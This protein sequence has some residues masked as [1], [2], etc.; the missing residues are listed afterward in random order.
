MLDTVLPAAQQLRGPEALRILAGC[1][2]QK[3]H[4]NGNTVTSVTCRLSNGRRLEVQ[5]NTIV[6]AAGAVS[7]SLLLL[8]SGI[9][10]KQVGTHLAFNMGSPITAVFDRPIN[11]YDGL[12]IS[13][14]LQ[15]SPSQG[16]LLETWF[17][18]P[19][20]Q[21]LAMPGWFDDHYK[22]MQ[23][24]NHMSSVGVL[25][26]T[27][28]NATVRRA[29]LFGRE[30]AYTP[31]PGDLAKLV[32]GLILAGRIC[33]AGG[34]S[35]VLP[36]TWDYYEFTRADELE[37]LRHIIRQAGD[38]ALG[39][40]HPQGGNRLSQNAS[41]GVV[42][43]EFRVF[44]YDNLYVCDASVFPSSIGVNPQLTVMALAD[45]ASQFIAAAR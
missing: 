16:Y 1:E 42:N 10:G 23:R 2:A 44:G 37:R 40:G 29:G 38:V 43:P 39:T 17:N 13:H 27:E 25:V 9:G 8:R 15:L 22:N 20:A 31:T 5:G 4:G 6:V 7:S 30:I 33:C 45:Y 34:A 35:V 21:A 19:V 18:P 32:E 11:A 41:Q 28:A 3:L 36:H 26:P 12:Q 14:Y 24:Y